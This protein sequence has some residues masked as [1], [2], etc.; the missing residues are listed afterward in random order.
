MNAQA[1][2]VATLVDEWLRCGVRH[3]VLAP[4]SR[5]T[6]L[7]LALARSTAGGLALHVHPDERSAAFMAL[8]IGIAT[9]VP[10]VVVTTSGTAAV[11]L[12]PA[13]VEAD[14][15]RVPM[16][17]CTADR[18]P[19]LREVGAP[20]AIDQ[21]RLFGESVRWF[22]EPGVAEGFPISA[23]RSV[24]ARAV[25]EA[26]GAP[27]G[28]PGPVHVN[29]AFTEPLLGDADAL[30]E[31]RE[32][33]RPWHQ[34][35]RVSL[36]PDPSALDEMGEIDEMLR[37][38]RGVVVAGGP[39]TDPDAVHALAS[40]L[41][42]PVLADPRSGCRIPAPHT[43]AAFDSMLRDEKFASTHR[44]DVVL[45][46]GE[47]P[48]SKVL[49]AWLARSGARQVL[50]DRDGVWLDPD[51]LVDVLLAGDPANWCRIL[52]ERLVGSRAMPEEAGGAGDWE[53]SWRTA[54]CAAQSA[55]EDTLRRAR[56]TASAVHSSERTSEGTDGANNEPAVA[57]R[58]VEVMAPGSTLVVSS[59]M[60]VRDIEWYSAPRRGV[61]FVANRGANGIDGVVSTAVGVAL[62]SGCPTTLLIG[63]LAFLHDINA[64]LGLERRDVD[65]TIVVVDNRGG[66]IFSFLPQ[67]SSLDHGLFEQLFATPQEV[68]VAGIVAAHGLRVLTAHD[69]Q[70]FELAL[71][72]AGES[73]G[74]HVLVTLMGDRQRNVGVHDELH[75]AVAQAIGGL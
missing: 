6:P 70:G 33:G 1:T 51:R 56:T 3:A 52:R 59:S 67:A 20:Q 35:F 50:I 10:A 39:G 37:V 23:W 42:W 73:S 8:G 25:A 38:E 9:G 45:R 53:S 5:S 12:H 69:P 24:A 54:E 55:I 14:L 48:A 44:P 29:L 60:P 57:R 11:E 71:R 40:A 41:G 34:A 28:V 46:I 16:V 26:L 75:A 13:V 15:A 32:N 27:A 19:D 2:F 66:G 36:R 4:G 63:D 65:L 64:L 43:V 49:A 62:G 47:M 58:L 21:T 61:R 30:P 22:F 74:T 72:A 31:G 7:A 17:V 68:D 18:P